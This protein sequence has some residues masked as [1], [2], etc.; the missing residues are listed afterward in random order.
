MCSTRVVRILAVAVL[1]AGLAPEPMAR[2]QGRATQEPNKQQQ[3]L[4]ES[5]ALRHGGLAAAA[6]VTGHYEGAVS[7]DPENN[8]ETLAQLVAWHDLIVI[9]H[10]ESN[11]SWLTADGETIV[12]DYKIAVE[13]ILKGE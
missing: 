6:A 4:A 5:E 1:S 2:G 13:R 7:A 9:G 12:T 11:H 3:R 8:V 10:V